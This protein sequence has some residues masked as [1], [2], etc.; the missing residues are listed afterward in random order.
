M[1]G[2]MATSSLRAQQDTL[3]KPFTNEKDRIERL[4]TA[5]FKS[6]LSEAVLNGDT[7]KVRQLL[8]TGYVDANT[9]IG[10]WPVLVIAI[11]AGQ[12]AIVELLLKQ[13]GIDVNAKGRSPY[14]CETP[15]A[16]ATMAAAVG[17]QNDP[18]GPS[19]SLEIFKLL[20]KY[21][22]INVNDTCKDGTTAFMYASRYGFHEGME[23]LLEQPGMNISA[24]NAA[25]DTAYGCAIKG[26][27]YQGETKLN[28][29]LKLLR[30]HG[31][32]K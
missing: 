17:A 25:G 24:T 11:E 4:D 19:V 23:L 5:Y 30:A 14:G 12:K 15:L 26:A 6:D 16:V 2:I 32:K 29:T 21:P 22:G 9:R 1:I 18:N 28:E 31:L 7:A 3:N 20:L 27:I 8:N 10:I 13:Q